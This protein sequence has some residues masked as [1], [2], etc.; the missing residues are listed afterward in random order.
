MVLW[1]IRF[2][3]AQVLIGVLH[4]SLPGPDGTHAKRVGKKRPR[5]SLLTQKVDGCVQNRDSC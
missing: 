5:F 3:A 2:F 1:L 4:S